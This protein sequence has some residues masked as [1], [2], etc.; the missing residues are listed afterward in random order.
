M[1]RL[2]PEGS[3]DAW[4]RRLRGARP[5]VLARV[6]RDALYIDPRTLDD[7]DLEDLIAVFSTLTV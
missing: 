7:A 3:A 6:Q 1:V 2:E 5:P 4:A